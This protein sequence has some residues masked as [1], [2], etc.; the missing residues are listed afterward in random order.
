LDSFWEEIA[1]KPLPE[2][3]M[4]E[5]ANAAVTIHLRW[6]TPALDLIMNELMRLRDK[7]LSVSEQWRL[8]LEILVFFS[9]F[10][11]RIANRIDSEMERDEFRQN[12]MAMTIRQL[13]ISEGSPPDLGEEFGV[14]MDD[15]ESQ[16]M[17]YTEIYSS[18][19]S[20][21][22]GTL[23]WEFSSFL[24]EVLG[25]KK[26]IEVVMACWNPIESCVSRLTINNLLQ[27]D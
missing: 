26:Q 7:E 19:D 21:P 27:P 18:D 16:W 3:S 15:R 23:L 6:T 2:C 12:L 8:W 14:L 17:Q 5:R 13:S 4:Q 20:G 1:G 10:A 11:R 24:A 22:A 9:C 25:Y